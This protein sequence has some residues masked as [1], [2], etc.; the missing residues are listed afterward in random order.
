MLELFLYLIIGTL[1]M[2]GMTTIAE[3]CDTDTRFTNGE[4]VVSIVLW[5]VMLMAVIYA[6]IKE[7]MK[8]TK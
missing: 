7:I 1:F 2:H 5:P 3:K 8:N 6:S 4:V